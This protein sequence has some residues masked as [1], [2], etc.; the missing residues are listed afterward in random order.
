MSVVFRHDA[1]RRL[2]GLLDVVGRHMKRW[3]RWLRS[4]SAAVCDSVYAVT[5][6]PA[7]IYCDFLSF[8][9][10]KQNLSKVLWLFSLTLCV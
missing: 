5:R 9:Q 7:F 3:R 8:E 2:V 10:E 4:T 6:S 1:Y